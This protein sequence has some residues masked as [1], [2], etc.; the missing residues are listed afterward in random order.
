MTTGPILIMS[1]Q[2]AQAY[3]KNSPSWPEMIRRPV[4][5]DEEEARADEQAEGCHRLQHV[6]RF[7]ILS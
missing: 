1:P 5:E 4:D 7:T 2:K 6:N 3:D